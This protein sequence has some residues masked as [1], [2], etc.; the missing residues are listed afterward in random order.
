MSRSDASH[1]NVWCHAVVFNGRNWKHATCDLRVFELPSQKNIE[2]HASL[3]E[4][5]LLV[6]T[7]PEGVS[8]DTRCRPILKVR[9]QNRYREGQ[10]GFGT[11]LVLIPA[12][13]W[14]WFRRARLN[15]VYLRSCRVR[16]CLP[17]V[18]G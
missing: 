8:V 6:V 7:M 10:N 4:Y 3:Q 16:P 12:H 15:P 5:V 9:N 11:S 17:L 18:L 13:L 14:T 2:A 1:D